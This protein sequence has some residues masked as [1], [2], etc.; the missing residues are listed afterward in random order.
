M[1]WNERANYDAYVLRKAHGVHFL[2]AAV[3]NEF[4]DGGQCALTGVRVH[5]SI[6]KKNNRRKGFDAKTKREIF[7]LLDADTGH[8]CNWLALGSE[9]GPDGFQLLAV[10]APRR[11]KL[12]QP[13]VALRRV[14]DHLGLHNVVKG[15]V[16]Q[17]D[18]LG[19]LELAVHTPWERT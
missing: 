3:D 5:L 15:R 1:T 16:V 13:S 19:A 17:L 2:V 12:D 4:L 7:F 10:R 18:H 9:L 8:V 6:K 11:V 14:I